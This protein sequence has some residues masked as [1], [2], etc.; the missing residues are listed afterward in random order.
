MERDKIPFHDLLQAVFG[1]QEGVAETFQMQRIG[2]CPYLFQ[3]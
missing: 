3:I 2:E 1:S